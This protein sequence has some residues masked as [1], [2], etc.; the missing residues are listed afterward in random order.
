MLPSISANSP[1]LCVATAHPT[2]HSSVLSGGAIFAVIAIDFSA[3]AL[4]LLTRLDLDIGGCPSVGGGFCCA[5]EMERLFTVR[6]SIPATEN[7]GI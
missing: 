3:H 2:S 6:E 7:L 4:A 5:R 1:R